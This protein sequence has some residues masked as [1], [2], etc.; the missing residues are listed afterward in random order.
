MIRCGSGGWELVA[1]VV[2][3]FK[4]QEDANDVHIDQSHVC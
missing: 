2:R 1:D 4:I 3:L